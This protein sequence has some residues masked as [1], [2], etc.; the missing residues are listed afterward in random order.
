MFGT[1]F[2]N[3]VIQSPPGVS[4]EQIRAIVKQSQDEYKV[5]NRT[6]GGIDLEFEGDDLIVRTWERSPVKRVRRI[7]QFLLPVMTDLFQNVT[8]SNEQSTETEQ[9]SIDIPV[10]A[11]K[12]KSEEKDS[13]LQK[14]LRPFNRRGAK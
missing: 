8:I 9:M 5:I 12:E 1:I 7:E 13:T 6:L 4:P 3:I 2:E 10:E 14:I 11:P